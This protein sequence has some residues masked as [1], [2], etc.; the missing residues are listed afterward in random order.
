[1]LRF[2]LTLRKTFKVRARCERH[3]QFDP[4]H[5]EGAV[6]RD[7]CATCKE[8]MGLQD[9][10]EAF[11]NALRDLERRASAWEVRKSSRLKRGPLGQLPDQP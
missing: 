1:M 5:P 8:I 11:A 10:R 6:L 4:S 7:R 3:P 2:D 9:A